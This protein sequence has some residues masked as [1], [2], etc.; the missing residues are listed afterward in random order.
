ML[1]RILFSLLTVLISI[2]FPLSLFSQD[3]QGA[4]KLKNSAGVWSLSYYASGNFSLLNEFGSNEPVKPGYGAMVELAYYEGS[5]NVV[6][7]VGHNSLGSRQQETSYG[8]TELSIGPRV[9]LKKGSSL[10]LDLTFGALA[11]TQK[12]AAQKWI[13]HPFIYNAR[14]NINYALGL[15]SAIMHKTNLSQNTAL[16]LKLR[17]LA[18]ISFDKATLIFATASAGFSFNDDKYIPKDKKKL[19]YLSLTLYGGI[20]QPFSGRTGGFKSAG[21]F[22]GEAAYKLSPLVELNALLLINNIIIENRW[23]P[24]RRISSVTG[25]SRFFLSRNPITAFMEISTGYFSDSYSDH[26]P[27]NGGGSLLGEY[28]GISGGTGVKADVTSLFSIVLKGNF[29]FILSN[30]YRLTPDYFTMHGGLRLDL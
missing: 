25:G 9:E 22:G 6:L 16:V 21:S 15:S 24:G 1:A 8:V 5:K 12:R 20:N 13:D 23:N 26:Y 11:I 30:E 17:M 7:L 27:S 2:T 10:F 18:S 19:S 29:T 14:Y 28:M 4:P 3:E